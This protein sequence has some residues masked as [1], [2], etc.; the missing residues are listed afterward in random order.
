[1]RVDEGAF[2]RLGRGWVVCL[3][4][5]VAPVQ[6]ERAFYAGDAGNE[7]FTDVHALSDGT[8]LVSGSAGS[9]AWIDASVPRTPISAASIASSASGRVAFVLHL[10]ADL[11]RIRRVLHFPA[12]TVQD[13]SRLRSTEAPGAPTG[14]LFLSGQRETGNAATGGYF[15]AR[16]DANF[17]DATPAA[18]SWSVDVEAQGDY[19]RLQPWDV[20]G[21]GRV[22]Y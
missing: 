12:G 15:I 17:V 3:W 19:R 6:A 4:L 21:D 10:E 8:W 13:V 5:L 1:M 20:G 14:A 9:L 2:M 18:L 22:V 7:R 11:S 16:L